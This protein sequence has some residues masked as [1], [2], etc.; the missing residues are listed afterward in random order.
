MLKLLYKQNIK[1]KFKPRGNKMFKTFMHMCPKCGI[2]TEFMALFFKRIC[3]KCN[4]EEEIMITPDILESICGGIE[5]NSLPNNISKFMEDN[6]LTE[7]QTIEV[8]RWYFNK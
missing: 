4:Y 1:I 8:L 3:T 7:D 2:E 5:T 6:N